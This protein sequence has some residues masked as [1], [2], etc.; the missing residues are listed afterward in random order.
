[1]DSIG[2]NTGGCKTATD[3][4]ANQEDFDTKAGK[5]R[6]VSASRVEQAINYWS[7]Q[8]KP[9]AVV[10]THPPRLRRHSV[11]YIDDTRPPN[12]SESSANFASVPTA[13][14]HSIRRSNTVVGSSPRKSEPLGT[15]VCGN[16]AHVV[17][18][19]D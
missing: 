18:C 2:S 1:L 16:Q 15:T 7:Q 4:F 19:N 13:L 14:E 17:D 5:R 9:V 6:S 10:T 12:N 11:G 3:N 8:A